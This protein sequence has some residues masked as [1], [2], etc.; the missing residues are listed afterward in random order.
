MVSPADL[1]QA[2]TQVGRGG[3]ERQLL[4]T[5]SLPFFSAGFNWRPVDNRA[6]RPAPARPGTM[7]LLTRLPSF[8][9]VLVLGLADFPPPLAQVSTMPL[10]EGLSVGDACTEVRAI[11]G[12]RVGLHMPMNEE[13]VVVRAAH[14]GLTPSLVASPPTRRF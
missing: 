9:F 2:L 13:P 4:H 12:P 11:S 10:R 8:V 5:H 3:E 1:Q 14:A 7:A 6:L